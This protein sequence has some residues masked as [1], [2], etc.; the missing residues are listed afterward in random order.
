MQRQSSYASYA[1]P[2]A[3]QAVRP[4]W[5]S[6]SYSNPTESSAAKAVGLPMTHLPEDTAAAAVVF[7]F[8]PVG[9]HLV[10]PKGGNTSGGGSGGARF[11]DSA[12]DDAHRDQSP[13]QAGREHPGSVGW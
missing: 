3:D 11:E 7:D 2:A 10:P 9:H 1:L 12:G 13:S 8:Q 4:S 5:Q 6:H